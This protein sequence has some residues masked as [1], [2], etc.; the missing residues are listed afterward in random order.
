MTQ[1][2]AEAYPVAMYYSE[3]HAVPDQIRVEVSDEAFVLWVTGNMF[4]VAR[5]ADD[6]KLQAALNL[7]YQ[8][9]QAG[10]RFG[11]LI[12]EEMERRELERQA[13][14]A[15]AAMRAAE[16]GRPPAEATCEP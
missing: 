5:D 1:L 3:R 9:S 11:L 12:R 13:E 8:L 15:V 14:P 16:M 10:E 4:G 2:P 7:A 6:T